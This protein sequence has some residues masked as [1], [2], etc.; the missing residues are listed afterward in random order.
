[1]KTQLSAE[2]LW[3]TDDAD[4]CFYGIQFTEYILIWYNGF[5]VGGSTIMQFDQWTITKHGYVR[6]STTG[7]A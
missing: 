1:M 2:C 7:S 3:L 5:L 6:V 4:G